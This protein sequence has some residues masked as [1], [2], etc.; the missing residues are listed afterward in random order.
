MCSDKIKHNDNVGSLNIIDT[1]VSVKLIPRYLSGIL[2]TEKEYI[3]YVG[4]DTSSLSCIL[5]VKDEDS[6]LIV[7]LLSDSYDKKFQITEDTNAI[8]SNDPNK[9][10]R[11]HKLSNDNVIHELKFIL[12]KISDDYDVSK[13]KYIRFSILLSGNLSIDITNHYLKKSDSRKYFDYEYVEEYIFNSPLIHDLNQ[14]I[15][16]YSICVDEVHIEKPYFISKN[17]L[18]VSNI[19]GCKSKKIPKKVLDFMVLLDLNRVG[20]K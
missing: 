4:Q 8:I 10:V 9:K 5:S 19:L 2:F 16:V 13:L 11:Y 3:V 18:Y 7:E 6:T 14:I 1:M 15:G 12:K 17:S 20:H